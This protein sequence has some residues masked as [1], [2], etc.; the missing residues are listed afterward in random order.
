M[1]RFFTLGMAL[2]ASWAATIPAATSKRHISRRRR[3]AP[4]NARARAAAHDEVMEDLARGAQ[5]PVANAAALVP[6]FELLY[7]Q[8]H[9]QMPG[10]VRILQ[11]GDS[12]TAADLWS[13]EM[14][15]RFQEKFGDGGSGFSLAGR[16]R[17]Y[18][19]EDVRA[20]STRGWRAGGLVGKPGDGINGLGG[21]SMTARLPRQTV[22][23]SAEG[24]NFELFY[25]QQPGGGS[26]QIY[27]NG[28][29]VGRIS[30]DGEQGPGYYRYEA[31]PGEHEIEAETLDRAPVRLFGWVA[32]NATGVTYEPLGINGAQAS[33]VT[34]W[35]RAVLRSN[36][37][38][39]NPALIVLAYGTNEAGQRTWTRESY[40]EMFSGLLQTLRNAAPTAA[41]LVIGPPDRFIHTR[42]G[43][44]EMNQMDA[45]VEA[46]I[47]AA[48]ANGC[49]FLDMRAKMGGKGS[50]REWVLA[51]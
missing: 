12:H 34:H 28:S 9:G 1:G 41:I 33:I 49:A 8:Q 11:Y 39:R 36:V 42:K 2:L 19:R 17:G 5:I 35:D 37:E 10:P 26:V 24:Q 31:A 21:V 29:R 38:R 22:S 23:L 27:D 46:Q 20:S 25:W 50:M 40:G 16:L 30:T 32:E 4:V 14:R 7:R 15:A 44:V 3:S 48:T 18:H 47:G 6:F 13:G 51:G 43:W 45:I